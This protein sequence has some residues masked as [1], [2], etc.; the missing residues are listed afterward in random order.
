MTRHRELA[1]CVLSVS[2]RNDL[3]GNIHHVAILTRRV[4]EILGSSNVAATWAFEKLDADEPG[5]VREFDTRHEIALLLSPDSCVARRP[6][7]GQSAAAFELSLEKSSDYLESIGCES[8]VWRGPAAEIYHADLRSLGIRAVS[9]VPREGSQGIQ[10][11]RPSLLRHGIWH[12]PVTHSIR[13]PGRFFERVTRPLLSH[14][15]PNLKPSGRPYHVHLDLKATAHGSKG[16][17]SRL[18]RLVQQLVEQC[19]NY[20][21]R[22]STMR[23]VADGLSA[24]VVGH[25]SRSILRPAA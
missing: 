18:G 5:I 17:L 1:R 22:Q 21:L 24:G 3:D 12:I 13:W 23:D 20:K 7:C 10:N 15:L 16:D 8:I 11:G 4:A 6:R 2:V 25:P 9:T 14:G 19:Q